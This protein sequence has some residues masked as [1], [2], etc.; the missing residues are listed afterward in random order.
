M[1]TIKKIQKITKAGERVEKLGPSCTTGE[2]VNWCRQ[3]GQQHGG[4]ANN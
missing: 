2:S 4:A 3:S 1:A